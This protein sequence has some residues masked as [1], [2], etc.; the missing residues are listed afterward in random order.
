MLDLSIMLPKLPLIIIPMELMK[1]FWYKQPILKY[2]ANEPLQ[3]A[4]LLV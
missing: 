3:E 4:D 2:D 1:F